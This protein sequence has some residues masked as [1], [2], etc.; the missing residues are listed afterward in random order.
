MGNV[1]VRRLREVKELAD[2]LF[3]EMRELFE[4]VK[5]RAFDLFQQ[6]RQGNERELD[7]WLQAE[8]ELIW[9][10]PAEL[11]DTDKGFRLII[12]LSGFEAK[13][14]R[15]TVMPDAII[16]QAEASRK[17]DHKERKVL[18]CDFCGRKVFRRV[19]LPS[20]IDTD[21]TTAILKD[22]VLRIEAAKAGVSKARRIAV[23][24]GDAQHAA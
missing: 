23:E 2:P 15:L 12:G 8:R 6:R 4:N 19:N 5:H 16:L 20:E 9:P 24:A 22:G 11:T 7:D 21:K 18:F 10:P 17:H 13:D 1:T 14:I 3:L